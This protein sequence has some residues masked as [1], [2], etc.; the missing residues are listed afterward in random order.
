MIELRTTRI[1][2]I[3]MALMAIAAWS[4]DLQAADQI[5]VWSIDKYR[6]IVRTQSPDESTRPVPI[7]RIAMAQN[8]FRD[9]VFM[10]GPAERDMQLNVRVTV[11][12][13][14][15]DGF[16]ETLE[17][18][19]IKNREGGETGDAVRP[20]AGVLMVPK[21][22]SRQIYLRAN[23]RTKAVS[24]GVYPFKVEIHDVDSNLS[25]TLIGRVKVWD[26]ALP[27]Y[28]VL[29]NQCWAQF[30]DSDFTTPELIA[31]AVRDMKMFGINVLFIHGRETP[32]PISI[33]EDGAVSSFDDSKFR[34]RVEPIL[35]VWREQPVSERL[36]IVVTLSGMYD[37]GHPD[38]P[39]LSPMEKKWKTVFAQWLRQLKSEM[40]SMG[41]EDQDW[42]LT[43]A[44]ETPYKDIFKTEVPIAEYAKSVEP[45]IR[46]MTDT[47]L[48][49][50]PVAITSIIKNPAEAD[51]FF[52]AF[53]VF[54]P[55]LYYVFLRGGAETNGWYAKQ[56]RKHH[57]ELWTYQCRTDLGVVGTGPVNNPY[58]DEN[59]LYSYYRVSAWN[60]LKYGIVGT[61]VWTYC[62]QAK[63]WRDRSCLLVYNIDGQL[64]HSRR[65]EMYREGLD[66]YRYV[67]LLRKL[68]K[69][70]GAAAEE[71]AEKLIADAVGDI[72]TNVKDHARAETWR[73]RI[74]KE[75]ARIAMKSGEKKQSQ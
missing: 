15:P 36:R 46:L 49:N 29:P 48:N 59:N 67:W 34:A 35:K 42:M 66:D 5:R 60:L 1:P 56:V 68:A 64:V 4:N 21:G 52:K 57:K 19:Y 2:I 53:D 22:Q 73:L 63:N 26:F 30:E 27:P 16:I 20:L 50:D 10:I 8:E 55:N 18:I 12:G 14:P 40:R 69:E 33:A 74:A 32:R 17:T 41:V 72:T 45:D 47:S 54:Q 75:I 70:Q 51:R 37:F 9:A 28:D 65:F 61:G 71:K 13:N 3:V 58:Y 6:N 62:A 44:D 25:K 39:G 38:V 31:A 23:T 7:L 43:F 24:A 11:D